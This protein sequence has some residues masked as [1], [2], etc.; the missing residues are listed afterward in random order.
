VVFDVSDRHS[1]ENLSSW[2]EEIEKVTGD[3]YYM[4]TKLCFFCS[5][6]T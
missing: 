3:C 5:L 6:L 1:F 2:I 4:H